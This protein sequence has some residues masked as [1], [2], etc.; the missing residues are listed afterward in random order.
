MRLIE[1]IYNEYKKALSQ[2]KVE[3]KAPK[4]KVSKEEVD[5]ILKTINKIQ[6][7][8][9]ER[10]ENIEIGNVYEYPDENLP[11]FFTILDKTEDLYI[12][13]VMTPYWQLASDKALIVDFEHPISNKFAVL[14]II[15][16]LDEEFIKN[17]TIYIGKLKK[18]D[19]DIL[20]KFY[21]GEI[22]ELPKD[23]R[24]LSYPEE[25]GFYQ[26]QFLKD[27]IERTFKLQVFMK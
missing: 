9:I 27:E 4:F 11:I 13:L 24:G 20:Q 26:E 8:T 25:K 2:Q 15:L 16:N 19:I 22:E 14:P 10:T 23:R 18:E 5:K 7:S 21:N 17:E 12:A 6:P 3:G 1:L